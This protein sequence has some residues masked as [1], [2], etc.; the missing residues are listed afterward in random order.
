MARVVNETSAQKVDKSVGR[1]LGYARVS[2]AG[3]ELDLQID[4]LR[5][6]GCSEE[7]IY[8]DKAS[9][10]KAD[11]PGLEKCLAELDAGDVLL[12]WRLD[13]MG[14]STKHLVGIVE[15]LRDRGVG[16]RSLSD[17]AIDTTTASGELI[18]GI[19]LMA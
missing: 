2:T 4:A 9:G 14:R 13:R 6:A 12:V 8:V 1:L 19:Q 16:F 18:F 11:R 5:D 17:G 15:D 3:Q 10:A 7:L